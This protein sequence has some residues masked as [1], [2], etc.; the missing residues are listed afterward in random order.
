ME[1]LLKKHLVKP[2]IDIIVKEVFHFKKKKRR[3][4]YEHV[5]GLSYHFGCKSKRE[6]DLVMFQQLKWSQV[7]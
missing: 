4:L 6:S 1:L 2:L 5:V 7:P 3:S